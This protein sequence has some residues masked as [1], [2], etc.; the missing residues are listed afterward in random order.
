MSNVAIHQHAHE[1]QVPPVGEFH[2]NIFNED[3][4]ELSYRTSYTMAVSPEERAEQANKDFAE[5]AQKLPAHS[6]AHMHPWSYVQKGLDLKEMV[7]RMDQINCKY[8][9]IMPIPTSIISLMGDSERAEWTL[10]RS[11]GP[12]HHCGPSYYVPKEFNKPGLE[13]SPEFAV[14]VQTLISLNVDTE[15]DDYTADSF[16][17]LTKA[18]QD[19]LDP[20][21]TGLHLGSSFADMSLFKKMLR[22]PGVFTGAGE[23]TLNKELVEVLYADKSGQASLH[24]RAIIVGEETMKPDTHI[25]PAKQLMAALG[26]AG[27]PAC[28]HCDIGHY[29]DAPNDPPKNLAVF[30]DFLADEKVR[31][32][33]IVWAHAGGLGRFVKQSNRHMDELENMLAK[34]PNLVLD[35]SWNEVAKQLTGDGLDPEAATQRLNGWIAFLNKHSERIMF[36]SDALAPQSNEVWTNTLR[37]Y[38]GLLEKLTDEARNNIL[39]KTYERIYVGARRNVR[40]FENLVLPNIK[41]KLTDPTV[42][43]MDMAALRIFRDQLYADSEP[44]ASTASNR[45]ITSEDYDRCD[46]RLKGRAMVAKVVKDL[47]KANAIIQRKN[48]EIGALKTRLALFEGLEVAGPSGRPQPEVPEAP[49]APAPVIAQ[50]AVAG[51][52]PQP[53]RTK[54]PRPLPA[55]EP[56]LA[57]QALQAQQTMGLV[58]PAAPQPS[59]GGLS[60]QDRI[61]E[62]QN[63][64]L[65]RG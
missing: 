21:V 53:Q 24:E 3:R 11:S 20:M 22:N 18:E 17:V 38:S 8:S 28:I 47:E 49:E 52:P 65:N 59:V 60:I 45:T 7:A 23:L 57:R 10:L 27:M 31:H 26:V 51:T 58:R 16:I 50:A 39:L 2:M 61:R 36:G 33:T 54:T 56:Q 41:D 25:G 30:S 63:R 14:K 32:T 64:G 55:Q 15:V 1:A 35:I 5:I 48:D 34:H 43:A 44:L 62:L 37:T 4:P 29:L 9:V 6:D 40:K 19:R 46:D 12:L 42:D 13:L